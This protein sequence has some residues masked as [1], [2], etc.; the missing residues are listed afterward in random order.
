MNSSPTVSVW[1]RYA[2]IIKLVFICV[3]ALVLL[4]PT[5]MIYMIIH[6]RETLHTE[7]V[8]DIYDKWAGSQQLQ[9]PVLSVPLIYEEE[10][11]KEKVLVTR[12]YHILPDELTIAGSIHPE[13]LE[14][15]IYEAVVYRSDLQVSGAI[16]ITDNFDKENLVG[17]RESGA[18]LTFGLS[19]LRGIEDEV[20]FSWDNKTHSVRPGTFVPQL[21]SSGF[22]VPLNAFIF[23]TTRTVPFSINLLL[24]GSHHLT[25]LPLGK[26][27]T[28]ELAS[29]WKDPKFDGKFL[30]N[31]REVTE[32]GF[33]ASWKVLELNR[34]FPQ[35]WVQ[36]NLAATLA[37]SAFGVELLSPIDDYQKSTRSVKYAI[38]TI[39]LT[40]LMFFLV[41]VLG[42]N[43]IHPLQ[44][45]MVGVAICLFYILLISIS[46]HTDFNFAYAISSVAII[47]MICLY[48]RSLLHR[49]SYVVILGL[50][51]G[52]SFGFLFITINSQ[53]YALLLGS[54]G[55][56]VI[57]G[58]TMYLTRNVDWYR[59][60][61][62]SEPP[63]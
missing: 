23:D 21:I 46:E 25:F 29:S 2:V 50:I 26:T 48:A 37:D 10:V 6:E 16:K 32:T 58:T 62:H 31:H 63:V 59:I 54:L 9:G 41:E 56:F 14:R 4:I 13:V 20:K 51:L 19:D 39:G 24:K 61:S 60:S 55:L 35:S 22:H 27:T 34:N 7:V 28:V 36:G 43:N 17:I 12:Y 47:T 30:P 15:G 8:A 3:L 33:Q 18:L 53:D 52:G 49:I 45:A 11:N 5:G 42:K 1:T 57:L 44:Y 38:M 40:F